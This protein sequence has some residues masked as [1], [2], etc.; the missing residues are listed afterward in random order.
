M[1]LKG[2]HK[3]GIMLAAPNDL[4]SYVPL[5]AVTLIPARRKKS[6]HGILR[7]AVLRVFLRMTS[8]FLKPQLLT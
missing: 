7:A 6:L 5:I 8:V 3:S 4:N 2:S 1:T